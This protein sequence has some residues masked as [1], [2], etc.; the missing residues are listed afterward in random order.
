M[1]AFSNSHHSN[2][3][4]PLK[5]YCLW[6]LYNQNHGITFHLISSVHKLHLRLKNIT[7]KF[8]VH[9]NDEENCH[10]AFD[11]IAIKI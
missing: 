2:H 8:R 7:Q 11:E 3:F 9:K 5:K 6:V 4:N 1:T 10:C